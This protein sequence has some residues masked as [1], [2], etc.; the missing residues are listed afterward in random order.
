LL[1]WSAPSLAAPASSADGSRR[2]STR[3]KPSSSAAADPQSH[4]H[5]APRRPCLAA[6][7]RGCEAPIGDCRA[8]CTP[9]PPPKVF[10]PIP[11]AHIRPCQCGPCRYMRDM[12]IASVLSC[13]AHHGSICATRA[14]DA[15]PA[16][17]SPS[18]GR[19]PIGPPPRPHVSRDRDR[20]AMDIAAMIDAP[21]VHC[22]LPTR[23]GSARLLLAAA[24]HSLATAPPREKK[25]V[26]RADRPVPVLCA[27]LWRHGLRLGHHLHLYV[28]AR[29]HRVCT[30]PPCSQ[31]VCA[32]RDN[33]SW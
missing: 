20:P 10:M 4:G 6:W 7:L 23:T 33:P 1:R 26:V 13:T 9:G 27:L 8:P 22:F 30:M 28:R 31:W 32:G 29:A 12:A 3:P 2:A 11:R 14:P 16:S 25:N 21:R 24:T 15:R 19:G 17:A 18:P 5:T